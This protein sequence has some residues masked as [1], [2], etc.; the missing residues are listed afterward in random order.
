MPA[1]VSIMRSMG[2][3]ATRKLTITR[4]PQ[5]RPT[6]TPP[7][8]QPPRPFH[9]PPNIPASIVHCHPQSRCTTRAAAIVASI[10]TAAGARLYHWA[11]P[12][13][14][15][16]RGLR[17]LCDAGQSARCARLRRRFFRGW[18]H[19]STV[20]TRRHSARRRPQEQRPPTPPPGAAGQSPRRTGP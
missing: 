4:T 12:R 1:T 10:V 17:N 6:P 16:F 20:Q 5:L 18:W 8:H 13:S 3:G 14:G 7:I 19:R 11:R 2:L 9:R 15:M